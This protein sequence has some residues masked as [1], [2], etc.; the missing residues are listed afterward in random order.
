[1]GG[2]GCSPLN[3]SPSQKLA[4]GVFGCGKYSVGIIVVGR[5]VGTV[6]ST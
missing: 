6:L 4:G 1:M 2:T 3:M 5:K